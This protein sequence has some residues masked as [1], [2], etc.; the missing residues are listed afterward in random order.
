LLKG[1]SAE[2]AKAEAMKQVKGNYKFTVSSLNIYT[3]GN[4]K[5]S[6]Y[7]IVTAYNDS[8]IKKIEVSFEK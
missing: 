3:S 6:V 4:G 8:E 1:E 2:M 5:T 7:G